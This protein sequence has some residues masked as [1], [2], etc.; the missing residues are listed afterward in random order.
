MRR[1][2][3]LAVVRQPATGWRESLLTAEQIADQLRVS[4]AQVYWPASSTTFAGG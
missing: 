1:H 4:E 2:V 3:R